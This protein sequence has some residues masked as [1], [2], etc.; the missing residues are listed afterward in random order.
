MRSEEYD[1]IVV[2]AGAAGVSAA[3][4]AARSGSRTV[5]IDAG[6]WA[7]GELVGGLPVDSCV[8][9][10]GEW[11]VG[12]TA[13]RLFDAVDQLGGYIGPVFDWRTMYAVCVDPEL[14]KLAVI[15]E[16]AEAGVTLRLYTMVEDVVADAAGTVQAVVTVSKA[17]RRLYRAPVVVDC[18]G[19]ADV[20]AHAGGAFD[21]GDGAGR[22]QPVSLVYRL[23]PVDYD[24]YLEFVRDHPEEFLLAENPAIGLDA[25]E[26]AK[27]AY[28]AGL[29]HVALSCD[30]PTLKAAI[31]SGE[32][33]PCTFVFTWPTSVARGEVGLNTTRVAGVD[34]T[35]A[36][37]LSSTVATLVDQVR[38]G[39]AFCRSR[40]PGFDRAE[41]TAVAPRIGVRETRRVRGEYVLSSDDVISGH[42]SV[43]GI[44]KGSHHVDIHGAGTDQ[45]RIPVRNGGSYDVPFGA[46]I[47]LGLRNVLVAGRCLSS[48]RAA[49]GS[50]RVM[51]TCLGTGQ[52]AGIAATMLREQQLTDVREL[53]VA[54]LRDRL[55]AAGAVL[56]GTA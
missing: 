13:R 28:E 45:I 54:Q 56:D 2:G 53:D 39:M 33:Y 52:A 22:H 12:G 40:L 20:V 10:R 41:I 48:D 6:P 5:L 25:A 4:A 8:N 49:N 47:P 26:C 42:K 51:G 37:Q 50:A 44:A 46:L 18:S 55:Q 15:G 32:M 9:A 43:D 27:R 19:D 38:Q 14:M 16:L 17:G 31:D 36:T 35:D 21:A 34:G 3:L 11:I 1:V 24:A 23:G 30:G 29:P 7:G